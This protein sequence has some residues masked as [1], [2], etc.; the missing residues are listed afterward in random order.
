M[1]DKLIKFDIS[2]LHK[3]TNALSL[4]NKL[5]SENYFEKADDLQYV[6]KDYKKASV[7]YLKAI[8]LF[9]NHIAALNNYAQNLRNNIKDY[10][11][12]IIFYSKV[13][14][15]D[16]QYEYA[17]F[18]RGVCKE[19]LGD[20][21]GRIDDLSRLIDYNPNDLSYYISRAIVR[22]KIK[23]YNGIID[24][25]TY[26][27]SKDNNESS[28]YNYRGVAKIEL[29]NIREGIEDLEKAIEIEENKFKLDPTYKPALFG[30]LKYC[31]TAK[32]S[33]GDYK[34]ALDMANRLIVFSPENPQPYRLRANINQKLGNTEEAGID[35]K[36]FN[37]LNEGHFKRYGVSF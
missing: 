11:E 16:P 33:I 28:A 10:Q 26:V 35:L 34:G 27:I 24:D 23:D 19:H 30:A 9:P 1:K 6:Q 18:Q 31:G 13:I 25:C 3:V 21:L 15:L 36:I 32:L 37:K 14:D 22:K 4:S 12:A 5:I 20:Y 17:L 29:S 2:H 7:Y 8:E